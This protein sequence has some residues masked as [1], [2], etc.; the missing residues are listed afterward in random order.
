[1]TYPIFFN[2]LNEFFSFFLFQRSSELKTESRFFVFRLPVENGPGPYHFQGEISR[3][4]ES[5]PGPGPGTAAAAHLLLLV[6]YQTAGRP[7]GPGRATRGPESAPP[8]GKVILI[9]HQATR[10]GSSS[11]PPPPGGTKM[12]RHLYHYLHRS[13]T[14]KIQFPLLWASQNG[15]FLQ[16][17]TIGKYSL[18]PGISAPGARPENIYKSRPEG[19]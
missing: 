19:G 17:G 9:G 6:D 14:K 16:N 1:M 13:S 11:A 3:N 5:I 10:N 18:F 15:S 7:P 8:E 4:T 2:Q 12:H